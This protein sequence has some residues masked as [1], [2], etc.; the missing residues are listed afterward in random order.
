M[1]L[2]DDIGGSLGG[3]LSF[4]RRVHRRRITAV[5]VQLGRGTQRRRDTADDSPHVRLGHVLSLLAKCSHGAAQLHFGRDHVP[6]VAAVNLRDA[7]DELIERIHVAADDGLQ[8]GDDLRGGDDRI[9]SLMRHR[10]MS[11]VSSDDDLEDVE[12]GHDRA[13]ANSEVADWHPRPVVHS[14]D[15]VARELVEESLLDHDST[16]P[17]VLLGRLEDDVHRAGEVFRFG[18]VPCRTEQHRGVA[19]VSA[20]VHLAGIL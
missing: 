12:R 13:G 10:G 5:V 14:E 17:F 1:L 16:T 19:V 7:D 3:P 2:A 6:G 8:R 15:S 20:S 18:E 11:A 4:L 9:D